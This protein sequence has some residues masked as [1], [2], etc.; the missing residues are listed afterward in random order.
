MMMQKENEKV[1]LEVHQNES[2]CRCSQCNRELDIYNFFK[3]KDNSPMLICKDCIETTL[4]ERD[5]WSWIKILQELDM[6][7]VESEWIILRNRY[8]DAS[9]RNILARYLAKMRL[10]SWKFYK[11]QDSFRIKAW[12][13]E[14]KRDIIQN[15]LIC[16]LEPLSENDVLIH[17]YDADALNIGEVASLHRELAL[18]FPN[19][20]IISIPNSTSLEKMPRED[21]IKMLQKYLQEFGQN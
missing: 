19:N 21:V 3:Y 2:L 5:P 10:Y 8:P 18:I 12:E 6:P 13:N 1:D 17:Y 20:L 11:F 9:L 14:K 16:K 15:E 4:D 7:W